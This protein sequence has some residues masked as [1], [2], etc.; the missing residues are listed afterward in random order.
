MLGK[1]AWEGFRMGQEGSLA[2]MLLKEPG[3]VEDRFRDAIL[4]KSESG[5]YEMDAH[6][7]HFKKGQRALISAGALVDET[8]AVRGVLQMVREVP[9]TSL[10]GA[11]SDSGQVNEA[12]V[13]LSTGS[14]PVEKS[15]RGIA[16][17]RRCSDTLRAK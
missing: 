7:P 10:D 14:M 15:A 1:E 16:G 12:F 3:A 13:S 11:L 9:G 4:S 2:D 8:G 5:W 17:V 6:L